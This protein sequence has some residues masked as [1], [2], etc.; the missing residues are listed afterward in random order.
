MANFTAL[1]AA[2]HAVL[3]RAG[4]DVEADGLFG[5][6]PVTVI[7]GEEVHPTLL[8]ALGLLGLGRDAR[9]ARA[10]GRAGP[11]ARRRAAR[12]SQGPTIVCLQAGNVNTGAFDPV[13]RHLRRAR[14]RRAPG[15][16]WTAPSACGPRRRRGSRHLLRRRRAR[17]LVGHRRAQVAQRA[18]RQR[19]RLRARRRRAA[20]GHGDHAPPTCLPTARSATRPTTRRSCRAARAASRCGRR[21]ARS[22]AAGVAEL[23][24]RSCRH[25]RRFAEGLRGRGLRDP[26]RR[27]A[28][29]GAGVVRRRR[30]SR[31]A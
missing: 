6:P 18:L 9:D 31:S 14:R 23:I 19:P 4:W 28:Q 16:T 15:C 29:P 17:R 10:R 12:A 24:E 27:G 2:R 1:A 22:A 5:A 3:A 25:A 20:R 26:Q 11:H 21:C 7:V 30:A 13:G 8:K